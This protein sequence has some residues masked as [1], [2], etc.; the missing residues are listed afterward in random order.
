MT[1]YIALALGVTVLAAGATAA[2]AI[3][4]APVAQ[5]S[6]GTYYWLHPKLG[7]VKVDRNTNFMVTAKR[8]A[9]KHAEQRTRLGTVGTP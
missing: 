8:P 6:S 9:T 7:H 5:E 2:P 1:K 4:S 3:A